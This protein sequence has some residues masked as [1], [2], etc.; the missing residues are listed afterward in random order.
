MDEMGQKMAESLGFPGK[1]FFLFILLVLNS[2]PL[3]AEENCFKDYGRLPGTA[4][5]FPEALAG[6]QN[7][8]ISQF[9]NDLNRMLFRLK[10][11]ES[12][13]VALPVIEKPIIYRIAPP[14]IGRPA[15]A[16][17][18]PPITLFEFLK[19]NWS[20]GNLEIKAGPDG[21]VSF[22]RVDGRRL[23]LHGL[24]HAELPTQDGGREAI[25]I[26]SNIKSP[27]LDNNRIS[28]GE[29]PVIDSNGITVSNYYLSGSSSP[30]WDIPVTWQMPPAKPHADV[31][32]NPGI[33][34]FFAK[35][36]E[37]INSGSIKGA[38]VPPPSAQGVNLGAGSKASL[39]IDQSLEVKF[40]G[41]LAPA[42]KG[43]YQQAMFAIVPTNLTSAINDE[44]HLARPF[45]GIRD[46][47]EADMHFGFHAR[48]NTP[49]AK[50]FLAVEAVLQDGK[51]TTYLAP[52]PGNKISERV[53]IGIKDLKADPSGSTGSPAS[54]YDALM[55]KAL[56]QSIGF[57]AENTTDHKLAFDLILD[58]PKIDV[59]RA[60][61]D[62]AD[63]LNEKDMV[64][65]N[66]NAYS[67]TKGRTGTDYPWMTNSRNRND[68]LIRKFLKNMDNCA[69]REI[70]RQQILKGLEG[71]AP[72][73][74][75]FRVGPTLHREID[76]SDFAKIWRDGLSFRVKEP[77][78]QPREGGLIPVE[79]TKSDFGKRHGAYSHHAMIIAGMQGMTEEEKLNVKELFN[80]MMSAE[81]APY[82]WTDW[83]IF[84]SYIKGSWL[85]P[86]TWADF[87][88]SPSVPACK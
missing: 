62:I 40:S 26:S 9:V 83:N 56:I 57:R 43:D 13:S 58:S 70:A 73:L 32:R 88:N 75:P 35:F 41:E 65:K 59:R 4:A 44:D 47:K 28:L 33:R 29:R 81:N 69:N 27:R 64:L 84:E 76:I 60:N 46:G 87:I 74:A 54:L 8:Q 17:Y 1:I 12:V 85:N 45:I 23:D 21:L 10:P 67:Q 63:L 53:G 6:S 34:G 38:E 79:S 36:G 14:G 25:L 15:D 55:N 77:G 3:E 50:I 52:F 39:R 11:G 82:H 18:F 68:E 51:R 5:H 71:I 24:V 78:W 20:L 7:L 37:K 42:G 30:P 61:G 49:E 22:T 66:F 31:K 19:S 80:Q 16:K 86:E 2:S 48:S 72:A